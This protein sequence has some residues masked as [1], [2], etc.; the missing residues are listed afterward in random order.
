[1]HQTRVYS[2]NDAMKMHMTSMYG[3]MSSFYQNFDSVI[4]HDNIGSFIT[5]VRSTYLQRIERMKSSET[6]RSGVHE[7]DIANAHEL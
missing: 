1:M 3:F 6:C 5:H 4:S 2:Y 7:V